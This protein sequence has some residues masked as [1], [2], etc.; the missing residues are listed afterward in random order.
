MDGAV[1]DVKWLCCVI[2]IFFN[3]VKVTK[4][5]SLASVYRMF[6]CN[7]YELFTPMLNKHSTESLQRY[8]HIF[9]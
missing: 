4:F 8:H 6:F 9:L 5:L 7:I 2:L 3:V 1:F